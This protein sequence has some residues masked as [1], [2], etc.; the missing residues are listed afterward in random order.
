[1]RWY[2]RHGYALLDRNWRCP[3][4]ELDLVLERDGVVVF[5]EVKARASDRYG[6]AAGAV[7]ARKQQKLRG[8][9]LAWLAAHP[10]LRRRSIRFDVAAVTNA[11]INVIE[12][13]F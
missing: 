12:S 7:D 10:D 8:L 3:T 4:G 13:A 2:A 6:P 11:R 9:A 1:M 5:C